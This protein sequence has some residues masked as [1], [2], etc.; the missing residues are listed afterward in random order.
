MIKMVGPTSWL[1]SSARKLRRHVERALSLDVVQY[2]GLQLPPSYLRA[3]GQEFR[4]DANFVETARAD[5]RKLVEDFGV[6]QTTTLLEIGCGAG[7]FPIGLLAEK[8]RIGT[9]D[10]V[11]INP[12][13]TQWCKK[14]IE[15]K[16]PNFKFHLIDAAHERYNPDG[17]PMDDAFSLPFKDMSFDIIYLQSVFANMNPNDILIYCKEMNR[18]LTDSGRVYLTAFIEENVNPY[19]VNPK[20]YIIES[21]G[22]LNV[23]RYSRDNF[24]A[25]VKS[26]GLTVEMFEHGSGL[27]GQ[28]ILHLRRSQTINRSG[29]IPNA[30]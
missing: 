16:S 5:A 10:G 18:I 4:D 14:Y 28:S 2:Q 30:A 9:Y 21:N 17:T 11:D 24:Y 19:E 13:T 23:A 8:I 12:T 26:S 22:P 15:R 1:K 20:D 29:R 6:Q 7:R 3:C 25:I 27:G